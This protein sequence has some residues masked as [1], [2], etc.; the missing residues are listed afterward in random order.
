MKKIFIEFDF[1]DHHYNALIRVKQ[2]SKERE[3][4]VTILDWELERLLYG[5][6]LIR[7]V[8]GSIQAN[9]R[10]E[11]KEQTEL[12]L[13]IASKLGEFLQMPC[14]AG[15][16]CVMRKPTQ[17]GW[18]N[19]HPIP[20]H[21]PHNPLFLLVIFLAISLLPSPSFAQSTTWAAP[22]ETDNIKN[23][24]A[25]NAV[26]LADA[27][28][29]YIA[30]CGPCHGEKGRGD[31]PAAPGLNPRPADHTSPAIQNET[32]GSLFWKLSEG[33]NP[34]PGYK[35]IFTEQQRWELIYYIRSLAKAGKKK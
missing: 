33:R 31:G 8:D 4:D 25:A 12:K 17:E 1:K 2:K 14:F 10:L 3:F 30:N 5:N 35:K 22:K 32:D 11:K 9:L 23:P 34:M 20:R 27:R 6:H 19:L 24:I 29:L 13:I 26:V 28:T 16:Q 7:E 15:D 18:E 21:S